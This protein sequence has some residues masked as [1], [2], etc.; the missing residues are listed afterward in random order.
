MCRRHRELHK[1]DEAARQKL[2]F[3]RY[4]SALK[5]GSLV[6]HAKVY[7]FGHLEEVTRTTSNAM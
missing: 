3:V 1:D 5:N 2:T 6:H 4:P 7:R